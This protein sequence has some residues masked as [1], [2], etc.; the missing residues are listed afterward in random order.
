VSEQAIR[1]WENV[2]INIPKLSESLLRL[3]YREHIHDR[4]GKIAT[5]L[6]EI[7]NLEDTASDQKLIF[8]AT[9][10]G[11]RTAA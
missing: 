10:K 6:K 7:A 8:K 1:C 9:S 4:E 5:I 3:L 11:W 2:K